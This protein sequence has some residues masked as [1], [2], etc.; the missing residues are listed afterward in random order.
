MEPDELLS[1]RNLG[2][3]SSQWLHATGIHTPEQLRRLG[4]VEAYRAVRARGFNASKALLFAIAGALQDTHWKDLDPAY[5]QRLLDQ[6]MQSG[7]AD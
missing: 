2:K 4:P 7:R 1:L 3:T 5:K 6:L